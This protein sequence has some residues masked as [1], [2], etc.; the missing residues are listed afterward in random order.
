[1]DKAKGNGEE[2]DMRAVLEKKQTVASVKPALDTIS[3]KLRPLKADKGVI[4]L[5]RKNPSHREWFEDDG[6][7]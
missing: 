2:K 4:K 1:M 5:D 3:K 7:A 6:N